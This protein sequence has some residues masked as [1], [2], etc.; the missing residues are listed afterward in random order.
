MGNPRE[1]AR[2]RARN[3]CGAVVR[4]GYTCGVQ[5][6]CA[7]HP[8]PTPATLTVVWADG[9]RTPLKTGSVPREFVDREAATREAARL[10]RIAEQKG[11]DWR[12]EAKETD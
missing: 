8:P 10:N 3:E 12:Y 7:K 1:L 2:L 11:V 4:E 5:K 9:R 6:P